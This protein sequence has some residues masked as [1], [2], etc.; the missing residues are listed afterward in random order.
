ML[1][2][3]LRQDQHLVHPVQ[4]VNILP[5]VQ[6]H[7]LIVRLVLTLQPQV[8]LRVQTVLQAGIRLQVRHLAEHVL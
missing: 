6:V 7:V 5:V 2:P 8:L 3:L 1:V 4:W